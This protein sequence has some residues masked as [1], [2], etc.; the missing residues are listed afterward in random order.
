MDWKPVVLGGLRKVGPSERP[1]FVDLIHVP[2]PGPDDV[3]LS[4]TK[5]WRANKGG[6]SYVISFDQMHPD[7]GYRATVKALGGRKARQGM[8]DVV[9]CAPTFE[10]AAAACLKHAKGKLT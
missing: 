4:Q 2:R 10:A 1:G 6:N 9:N 8:V 7:L 5:A 3:D